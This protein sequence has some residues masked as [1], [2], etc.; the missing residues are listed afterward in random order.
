M[1]PF[2][3][4]RLASL[5][6][7]SALAFAACSQD[8]AGPVPVVPVTRSVTLDA[9]AAYAYLAL[10]TISQI[11]S[12]AD[13]AG[14]TAW[15]M[16]FFSTTITLNGGAAGPGSV[17]A[18]CVCNNDG[19]TTAEIQAMTPENQL[20]AFEAVTAAD[21]PSA[22]QFAS[23]QLD[24]VINGW[25]SGSG[26]NASLVAGR[27]WIVR[28]GSGAGVVL[29]K[30]RVAAIAN[31]TAAG[32]AQ[33]TLEY[34]VQPSPGAAFGPVYTATFNPAAGPVYVDLTT[35]AVTGPSNWDLRF[36]GWNIL[37]NGGVSGSGTIRAVL[38][39]TTPF[40]NIDAAYAATAPAQAYRADRYAGVFN[41]SPW[42]RY[43]ITGTDNQIWP[44]FQVYLIRRGSEVFKVQ[45]VS[46]YSSTGTPRQITV[47]YAKL[48]E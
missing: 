41:A 1:N 2:R 26:Q 43:N 27:T 37:V 40:A 19:A 29:A 17:A 24:P 12:V 9:S 4:R 28:E 39:T 21:I 5:G 11:V 35:A 3:F 32:P 10:D 23:D 20:A 46:Y 6:A 7:L 34:A 45:V 31:Q 8:T 44:T 14:S 47:R 16:G 33:L 18:W 36:E 22:D 13:P 25:Y 15:D 42:Y 30:V 48:A 38:D